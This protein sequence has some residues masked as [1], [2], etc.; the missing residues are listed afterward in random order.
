MSALRVTETMH[1]SEDLVVLE[2]LLDV[3]GD[4]L[5]RAMQRLHPDRR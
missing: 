3:M 1:G 5:S 2:D 4:E